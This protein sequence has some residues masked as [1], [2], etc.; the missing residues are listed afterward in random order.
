MFLRATH[1]QTYFYTFPVDSENINSIFW[2]LQY[3]RFAFG[4]QH[5]P[6]QH[7][8]ARIPFRPI[9]LWNGSYM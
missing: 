6:C 8:A 9:L 7:C 4:Q 5:M 2:Y 1:I 3:E